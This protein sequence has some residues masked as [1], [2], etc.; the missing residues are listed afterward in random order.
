M[1]TFVQDNKRNDERG[2]IFF[3]CEIIIKGNKCS[4]T[5]TNKKQE[6]KKDL[7]KEKKERMC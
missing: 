5:N 3:Y 7:R 4:R 1:I 6:W 2:N